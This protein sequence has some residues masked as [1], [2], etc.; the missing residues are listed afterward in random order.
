MNESG[1]E[2]RDMRLRPEETELQGYWLDLGSAVVPDANWER[3]D[4]LTNDYLEPVATSADGTC[5]LY[6]DPAD[7]R[8]W[9]LSR[10]APEMKDGG[11]PLLSAIEA[12]EAARKFRLDPD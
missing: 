9:E 8:F 4:M 2:Q 11:P 1:K 12:T 10:V 3:I 6:R 5:K 7:G